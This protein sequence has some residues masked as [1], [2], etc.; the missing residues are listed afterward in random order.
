MLSKQIYQ[1][2]Q[3]YNQLNGKNGALTSYSIAMIEFKGKLYQAIKG[4]STAFVYIR[5]SNDGI[6]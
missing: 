3:L 6:T 1:R 4:N 2:S 5:S